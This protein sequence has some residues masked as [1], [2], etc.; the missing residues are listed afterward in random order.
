[1]QKR[2]LAIVFVAI[3]VSTL[4]VGATFAASGNDPVSQFLQ[5]LMGIQKSV[6]GLQP[7]SMTINKTLY[8]DALGEATIDVLPFTENASYTGHLN[9]ALFGSAFNTLYVRGY[10]L[11]NETSTVYGVADFTSDTSNRISIDFVCQKMDFKILNTYALAE[12]AIL[13]GMLEYTVCTNVTAL[14]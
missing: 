2:I 10:V 11:T 13:F 5:T 12:P 7:T 3:L 6:N 1:M 14:P 4:F 8:I 9:L